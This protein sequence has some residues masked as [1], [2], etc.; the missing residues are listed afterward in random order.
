LVV[1]TLAPPSPASAPRQRAFSLIEAAIVLGIVGLVIGGIWTASTAVRNQQRLTKTVEGVYFIV[2]SIQNGMSRADAVALGN[3]VDIS[4][5]AI[6]AGWVPTDW[7]SGGRL[8]APATNGLYWAGR[9][10]LF[11]QDYGQP[12]FDFVISGLSKSLCTRLITAISGRSN[13]VGTQNYRVGGLMYMSTSAGWS[14]QT[15]PHMANGSE[16]AEPTTLTM[17]FGYTRNN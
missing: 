8:Y 11:N 6:E 7:V 9:V 12:Q 5:T 4:S 3:G 13:S 15:F 14:T 1:P 16:C 17:K 2:S 10:Y